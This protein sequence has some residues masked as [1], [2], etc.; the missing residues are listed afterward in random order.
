M[1][2]LEG[3]TCPLCGCDRTFG[4]KVRLKNPEL[5]EVW[6]HYRGCACCEWA[7]SMTIMEDDN[8]E[9][10]ENEYYNHE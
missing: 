9:F 3:S 10:P 4:V 6:G 8:E 1:K 2:D 5:G 7:S